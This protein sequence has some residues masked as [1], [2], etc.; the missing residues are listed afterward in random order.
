MECFKRRILQLV[1]Y[2]SYRM[3]GTKWKSEYDSNIRN[4]FKM[5][6]TK[7]KDQP[8]KECQWKIPGIRYTLFCCD[9]AANGNPSA[10]GYGVIAR[11][12][13]SQVIGTISG[14]VGLATSFI[15][16]DVSVVF[17]TEW[18]IKLQCSKI[19]IRSS[20][21]TVMKAFRNGMVPWYLRARWLTS[22]SRLSDI[23]FEDCHKEISFSAESLARYGTG[24]PQGTTI[25]HN[26]RPSSL[27]QVEMPHTTYYRI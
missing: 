14:S 26:G 17:T 12:H 18:A 10:E 3:N 25:I 6:N 15:A 8:L 27:V 24:L 20:D 7:I 4:F 11:N 1:F 21:K 9:G 2:G 22:T 16:K 19:I 13:Q 5:E 23:Q